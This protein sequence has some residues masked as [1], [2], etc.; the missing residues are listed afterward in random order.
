MDSYKKEIIVKSSPE[1]AYKALITEEGLENWWTPTVEMEDHRITFRF[2]EK[3]YVVVQREREIENKEV[4]WRVSE[5][6]FKMQNIDKTD[7]WVGTVMYWELSG[8]GLE[9]KISFTH[10]GLE[11]KL[12]CYLTCEKGWDYFLESLKSYL[13]TG[14]GTPHSS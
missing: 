7:E 3:D 8:E 9:T 12:D 11:P 4:V 14:K 2:G 6:Y 1:K 5:Q 10:E 13:E